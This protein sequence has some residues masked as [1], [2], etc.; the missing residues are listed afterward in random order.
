MLKIKDGKH[1]KSS[2]SFSDAELESTVESS[3]VDT[4]DTEISLP[5]SRNICVSNFISKL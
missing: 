5:I 2:S 4:G 1:A 3:G